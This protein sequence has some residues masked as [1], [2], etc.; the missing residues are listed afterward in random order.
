MYASLLYISFAVPLS[1]TQCRNATEWPF[2]TTSIWN[3]PIGSN[4]VFAPANIYKNH[5]THD[6]CDYFITHPS[7]RK[8]C[9]GAHSG[10]TPGECT[11]LG[12]CFSSTPEPDPSHYP[13]CFMKSNPPGPREFHNDMEY[14]VVTTNTDPI[15]P[16]VNQGW[17]G[18]GPFNRSLCNESNG[19]CHCMEVPNS[20]I[21]D[22]IHVPYNWTTDQRHPN[23]GA[24][25]FLLPDGDTILQ[26]QPTYRCSPG[27][28]V[29]SLRQGCPNPYPEYESIKGDGILGAHGG[30]GLSAIGGMIRVAEMLPNSPPIPHA[31]KIELFAHQYYYGGHRLNP[32]N[33]TNGGRTQYVW[34]AIG[35]D[36]YTNQTGS[37][38][39]YNGTLPYL[40]PGA[41]LAIPSNISKDMKMKTIP[42]EKIK[43]VMTNFG[44]YIIDDTACDSASLSLEQGANDM[45]E[46]EYNLT[47]NTNGG[48]WYDDLVTIFQALHVV[49]NNKNTSVGGGGDPIVPTAPPFCD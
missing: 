4:A 29:L 41:L 23:N 32:P 38:L 24:A 34:P 46:Q 19:H 8:L 33:P 5:T 48:P 7:E 25:S 30:S 16:W 9:P 39:I 26:M 3:T 37:P 44:G 12:C 2:A 27:S 40:V 11:S 10:I 14:F 13:W 21:Q 49:I 17:W 1:H 20:K 6:T 45:F 31:I 43:T 36:G 42:G 22:H 18:P 35:S 47:L 15:T 28:P